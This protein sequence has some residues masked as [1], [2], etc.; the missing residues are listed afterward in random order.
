VKR[1]GPID[2][3]NARLMAQG[4]RYRVRYRSAS[5]GRDRTA[6]MVYLDEDGDWLLFDARPAAGTQRMPRAWIQAVEPVPADTPT[7]IDRILR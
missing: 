6:V 7:Y 4:H 1:K 3:D 2:D 5:Q